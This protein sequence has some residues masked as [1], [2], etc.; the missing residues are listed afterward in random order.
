MAAQASFKARQPVSRAELYRIC[1]VAVARPARAET[2]LWDSALG[3]D[4][5]LPLRLVDSAIEPPEPVVCVCLLQRKAASC[6]SSDRLQC[7][8]CI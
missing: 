6:V 8:V 7:R 4:E 5:M 2:L 1:V 3:S